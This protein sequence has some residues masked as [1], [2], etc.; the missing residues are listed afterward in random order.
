[1]KQCGSEYLTWPLAVT[2]HCSV[3]YKMG[4]CAPQTEPGAL[5]T[6]GMLELVPKITPMGYIWELSG[7]GQSR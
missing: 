2:Q 1:M 6:S 4:L 5:G 3:R 7:E